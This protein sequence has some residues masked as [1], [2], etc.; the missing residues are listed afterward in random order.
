MRPCLSKV[1]GRESKNYPREEA[2]YFVLSEAMHQIIHRNASQGKA[3]KDDKVVSKYLVS[4]YRQPFTEEYQE[5]YPNPSAVVNPEG[6]SHQG[7]KVVGK[8][9]LPGIFHPPEPVDNSEGIAP[10]S[11]ERA[12]HPENQGV[13]HHQA[14]NNETQ[15]KQYFPRV[16]FNFHFSLTKPTNFIPTPTS[17]AK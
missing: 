2:G 6:T 14:Q 9:M 13:G 15:K 10:I 17:K 4:Q 16:R 8:V 11:I 12:T 7:I 5:G 3:E 1:I